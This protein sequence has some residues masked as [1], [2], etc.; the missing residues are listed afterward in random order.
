[1]VSNILTIKRPIEDDY[2]N[3]TL[4][5]ICNGSAKWSNNVL[6]R[7]RK[8]QHEAKYRHS[9]HF[10][11]PLHFVI[12][13]YFTTDA[14]KAVYKA[15]KS[16][17]NS[18][19][20]SGHTPIHC[21]AKRPMDANWCKVMLY[22]LEDNP[23]SFAAL[24]NNDNLP[25][26]FMLK[27]IKQY[28]HFYLISSILAVFPHQA[29][30]KNKDGITPL[31][32]L[33]HIYIKNIQMSLSN[34]SNESFS[35]LRLK[36][37]RKR[38]ETHQLR[39]FWGRACTM[40]NASYYKSIVEPFPNKRVWRIVHASVAMVGCPIDVALLAIQIHPEQLYEQDEDGNFPLHLIASNVEWNDAFDPSY[41]RSENIGDIA[42]ST[43]LDKI[44]GL[45]P[46]A[47]NISNKNGESPLALALRSGKTWEKGVKRLFDASSP[48]KVSTR[49]P[50]DG[51]YP[52]MQA[53][54]GKNSCI[55]SIYSLLRHRPELQIYA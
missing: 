3:S 16:A 34:D 33:S 39:S 19:N 43:L 6:E 53:A 47:A 42:T 46:S 14:I 12:Q 37:N 1:M 15:D 31:S 18:R 40:I 35:L 44:L 48:S 30:A 55:T 36:C 20:I 9:E 51:L 8:H 41:V 38:S 23:Q 29:N 13:K 28:G 49:D 21:A 54:V 25:L 7:V 17:S 24:D 26:H 45:Y 52:F 2:D 22:F 4:W 5:T 10:T 32:I 11:S 27:S 50:S